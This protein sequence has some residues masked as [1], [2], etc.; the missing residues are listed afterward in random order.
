MS[1]WIKKTL[2]SNGTMINKMGILNNEELHQEEYKIVATRIVR[3]YQKKLKI[4]DIKDLNKIHKYLFNPLYDWA[5]KYRKGNFQK[6]GFNF[7]E[8]TRFAYAEQDINKL[9]QTLSK[10]DELQ[11]FD[12]AKLIDKLNFMH[13]FREGN[14]RS[15]KVFIQ[16]LAANHQQIIDYPR[17]NSKMIRA[18]QD[19]NIDKIAD[20]INVES[21]PSRKIAYKKL[22]AKRAAIARKQNN[23]KR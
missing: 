1:D 18:L 5:G 9:L 11:A 23:L 3:L 14:G 7:L 8:Y 20:L 17:N 22:L 12:Y 10:K 13:P 21:T 16:C 2:Y 4:N 6:D 19:A 15:S